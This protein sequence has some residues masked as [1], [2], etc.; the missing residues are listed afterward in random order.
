M[1]DVRLALVAVL[2]LALAACGTTPSQPPAP[3]GSGGTYKLGRPYKIGGIWYYPKEDPNYDEVGMAS[4]YGPKFHGRR[5]ANGEVFDM[6]QLTAAHTTLPM[7]SFVRVTNLDNGRSLKLRINDRGPFAKGRI[8]DV[9]RR[10]AQLL[11]FEKQGVARVRVQVINPD[12]TLKRTTPAQPRLA[13]TGEV[14][15]PLFVQ[16]GAYS[17]YRRARELQSGLKDL[18]VVQVQPVTANGRT[19]YRLRIGPFDDARKAQRILD[20]VYRRGFYDAR[21]FTD[22]LG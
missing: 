8:I 5:T 21:I 6:N 18:G 2:A 20:Q 19:V 4:W 14:D 7:P 10:G 12:G 13:T 9:S 1:R 22:R 15:G 17:D 16:V 3:D 11:G